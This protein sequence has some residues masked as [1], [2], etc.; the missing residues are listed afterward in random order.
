MEKNFSPEKKL[1][2]IRSRNL[3]LSAADA[4]RMAGIN[5]KTAER[6]YNTL[7]GTL[8]PRGVVVLHKRGWTH[9]HIARWFGVTEVEVSTELGLLRRLGH[10]DLV[11]A[12]AMG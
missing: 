7:R 1:S 2:V 4:A 11:F 6:A 10:L 12:L 3:G 5:Q 9:G 8:D